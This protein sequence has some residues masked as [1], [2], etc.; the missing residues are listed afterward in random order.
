MPTTR[1]KSS[2]QGIVSLENGWD[3]NIFFNVAIAIFTGDVKLYKLINSLGL[4]NISAAQCHVT[5]VH[6]YD[7][8]QW[9]LVI[10]FR[11][12]F[13]YKLSLHLFMF[14]CF[15]FYCL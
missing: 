12:I 8:L 3:C 11:V 5:A 15:V 7:N 9:G 10:Y 6:D 14:H 1:C 13:K 4:D 2:A